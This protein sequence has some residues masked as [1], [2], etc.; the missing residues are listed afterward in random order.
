MQLALK[1]ALVQLE[2]VAKEVVFKGL[3]RLLLVKPSIYM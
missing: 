3:F 2:W 1:V